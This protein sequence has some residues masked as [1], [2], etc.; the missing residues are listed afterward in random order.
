MVQIGE[1][2]KTTKLQSVRDIDI[3][4]DFQIHVKVPKKRS[5]WL[6]R[7]SCPIAGMMKLNVD[8]CCF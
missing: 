6:V 2:L 5:P 4:Q 1:K 3:L 7:C 8:R